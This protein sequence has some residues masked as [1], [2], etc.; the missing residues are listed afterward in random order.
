VTVHLIAVG[1]SILDNF[2]RPAAVCGK[3]SDAA[4]AIATAKPHL[5]L[6][7]A[8]DK[9]QASNWIAAALQAHG[10]QSSSERAELKRVTAKA[11][12]DLWPAGISAEV[13][14][15]ARPP[16]RARTL[17]R[18]D[19]AFLV[20]SDTTPGLVAG[21]WNA[22]ALTGNDLD[23]VSYLADPDSA[24]DPEQGKAV[25]VR[26]SKM[27]AASRDDFMTAMK[28]MGTLGHHLVESAR[29]AADE[30]FLFYLSG[31]Y[32]AA[33]PYLIGLAEGLRSLD[34]KRPVK[35]YVLHE[36][37]PPGTS[38]I[39]L[40]LRYMHPDRVTSELGKFDQ[41]VRQSVPDPPLL[42]GYAYEVSGGKCILT[43][44][45]AGLSSLFGLDTPGLGE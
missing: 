9:D 34:R 1:T 36:S 24:T 4:A 30:P 21:L 37:A 11:R 40:P 23:R 25:I 12:P 15:L 28:G 18:T 45:G 19:M 17:P 7:A 5:L 27:D 14:T 39:E 35:A 32:K 13:A 20:C 41:G 22:I 8:G 33:I 26:V 43:A 3:D 10:Q 31:G 6:A 2:D 42:E 38:L 29:I 16:V 44:F